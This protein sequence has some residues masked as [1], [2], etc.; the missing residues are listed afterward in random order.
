MTKWQAAKAAGKRG[1]ANVKRLC[2]LIGCS[3]TT[4]YGWGKWPPL[5]WQQR[6]KAVFPELEV[7]RFKN[8]T[9]GQ[10]R[11]PLPVESTGREST[12]A[13]HENH[14]HDHS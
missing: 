11:R 12:G 3:R 2:D 8:L 5:L 9:V 4:F 14:V 13:I 7:H 6:I 1:R 10:P